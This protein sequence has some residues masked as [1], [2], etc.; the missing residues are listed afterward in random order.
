MGPDPLGP[1][2]LS[3]ERSVGTQMGRQDSGHTEG[4]WAHEDARKVGVT[5][6]HLKGYQRLEE[7]RK[8]PPQRPEGVQPARALLLDLW[9]PELEGNAFL[10]FEA[11]WV[12]LLGYSSMKTGEERHTDIQ[13]HA[14]V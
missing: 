10:S 2:S 3:E 5:L 14:R 12:V 13:V 7:A 6:S 11:T 1:M 8:R 4:R 9:P